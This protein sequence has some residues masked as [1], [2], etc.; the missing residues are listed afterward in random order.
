MTRFLS[1]FNVRHTALIFL[2]NIDQKK[3]IAKQFPSKTKK[4]C[5]S[6]PFFGFSS[7]RSYLDPSYVNL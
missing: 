6:A 4:G 5:R 1:S 2:I 3:M 7:T